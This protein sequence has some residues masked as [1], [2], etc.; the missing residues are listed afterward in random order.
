MIIQKN[1]SLNFVFLYIL[2]IIGVD[3]TFLYLPDYQCRFV[4]VGVHYFG[5]TTFFWTALEGRQMYRA[6][7]QGFSKD[8]DGR[9]TNL[10]RYV[11]GY[12]ISLLIIAF[13]LGVTYA[14]QF[15]NVYRHS[16]DK[17]N[18]VCWLKEGLFIYAFLLPAL[19]VIIYN[20]FV[21]FQVLRISIKSRPNRSR[22]QKIKDTVKSWIIFT[23]LLGI[24]WATGFLVSF[25]PVF[26]YIVIIWNSSNGI[27]MFLYT[28]IFDE[29]L[30]IEVKKRFG[31]A[32]D[33]A[34]N[35]NSSGHRQA[36]VS[37]TSTKKKKK[38]HGG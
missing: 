28:I 34:L 15:D 12:G 20:T 33:V 23:Y 14:L 31:F 17:D 1:R 3:Q 4:A 9:Y 13:T 29:A 21:C 27:F 6:L 5:L 37:H 19:A 11:F 7:V 2:S 22:Y 8:F 18:D 26:I 32:K 24:G 36:V 25:H 16:D 30:M 35:Y 10:L 38:Q